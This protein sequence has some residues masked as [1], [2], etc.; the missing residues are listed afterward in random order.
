[1]ASLKKLLRRQNLLDRSSSQ[2]AH[3]DGLSSQYLADKVGFVHVAEALAAYR[4]A[5]E[6]TVPP[7]LLWEQTSFLGV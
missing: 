5:F 1:M 4:Q 6:D 7:K 2:R 3:V